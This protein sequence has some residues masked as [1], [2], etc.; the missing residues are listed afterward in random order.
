[1]AADTSGDG[2]I[3]RSEFAKLLA[4][5]VYFNNLWHKF[6][7]MVSACMAEGRRLHAAAAAG[8]S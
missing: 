6:E 3:E 1:M 2:F 4:Y 7:D 5:I 8:V